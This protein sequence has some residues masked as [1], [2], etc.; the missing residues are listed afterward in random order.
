MIEER[1]EEHCRRR[2]YMLGACIAA[3][4]DRRVCILVDTLGNALRQQSVRN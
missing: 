1:E 2:L 3:H 4:M